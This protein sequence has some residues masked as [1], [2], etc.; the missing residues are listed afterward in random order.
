MV[1]AL[2][3]GCVSCIFTFMVQLTKFAT[4]RERAAACCH[5]AAFHKLDTALG[6][7]AASLS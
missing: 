3:D 4:V 2:L 6:S 5:A 7:T 1:A